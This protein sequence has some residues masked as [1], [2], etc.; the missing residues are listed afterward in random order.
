MKKPYLSILLPAFL[1]IFSCGKNNASSNYE[2]EIKV[3]PPLV[4]EIEVAGIESEPVGY[5]K[6]ISITK[7]LEKIV[8]V[9]QVVKPGPEI[10]MLPAL[11]GM[12]L[13]DPALVSI[14]PDTPVTIVLFDDITTGA[15]P[16]FILAVKLKPE[17][18]VQKQAENVG[19][20]IMEVDGWTLATM[21]PK[22]FKDVKDWSSLMAFVKEVPSD[23]IE[24]GGRLKFLFKDLEKMKSSV[25]GG[26]SMTPF[27]SEVQSHLGNLTS[28]SLDELATIEAVKFDVSLSTEEILTRTT[29][30]AQKDTELFSLFSAQPE[31]PT[32]DASQY[33]KSDGFMDMLV[34]LDPESLVHYTEYFVSRIEKG[35][36]HPK[37]KESA[38]K[39]ISLV[40]EG[41]KLYDGQAV[42]SYSTSDDAENPINVVQLG[43]TQ[44]S[45]E[46]WEKFSNESIS[47]IQEM[48]LSDMIKNSGLKYEINFVE[49]SVLDNNK[50]F[51]FDV[52]MDAN[53]GDNIDLPNLTSYSNTS[54]Y[55]MVYNGLYISATSKPKLLEVLSTVK[56]GIPVKN[57]I[58]EQIKLEKGEIFKWRIDIARYVE[59]VMNIVE[60]TGGLN[61]GDALD[62]LLELDIPAVTGS[63]KLGQGRVSTELS[64]PLQSIKAGVDYYE[65]ATRNESIEPKVISE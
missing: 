65:S 57:N 30:S 8:T 63:A 36:T 12:A 60:T 42:M 35:L 39:L 19:M 38:S 26:L 4:P 3:L 13:G 46:E 18:P 25:M 44:I 5:A 20:K 17:S 62:G 28:V 55:F 50:I 59:L 7:L 32:L 23:D 34:N 52:I 22:L 33:I 49:D 29:V 45:S 53:E 61:F 47:L 9:G 51:R 1:L 31:L 37:S 11:A 14:D 16:S 58:G 41:S 24:I 2:T 48:F 54:A 56:S 27:P 43:G 64:I 6:T 21:N 15:Q 40:R 10:A